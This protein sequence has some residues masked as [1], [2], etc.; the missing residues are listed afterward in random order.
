MKIKNR[1]K[2]LSKIALQK[3][4]YLEQLTPKQLAL[5]E[6]ETFANEPAIKP[7]ENIAALQEEIRQK[8]RE[9]NSKHPITSQEKNIINNFFES[10]VDSVLSKKEQEY[11]KIVENK[12]ASVG[13][14]LEESEIESQLQAAASKYN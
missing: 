12:S 6:T 1:K 3:E 11:A 13:E 4:K 7:N 8:V 9:I 14:P 5:V 2:I 10:I